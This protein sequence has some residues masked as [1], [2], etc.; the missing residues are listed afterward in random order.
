MADRLALNFSIRFEGTLWNTVALPEKHLVFLELRDEQRRLV[1][2]SG[3]QYDSGNF[4]WKDRTYSERWWLGLLTAAEGVLL[5]QRFQP[6]HPQLKTLVAVDADTGDF[7]WVREEFHLERVSGGRI[8]GSAGSE[9]KREACLD[10]A[11]GN[12]LTD[13][14]SS[15]PED[16]KISGALRPFL[17]H[18]GTPYF[19]TV[20]NYLSTNFDHKPEGGVEYLEFDGKVVISYH[21]RNQNG[22]AN[23]LLVIRESGAVLLNEKMADGLQGLGTDTFFILSGR[24]F[25]VMNGELLLSY[26]LI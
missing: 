23:Y 3:L 18:E 21:I 12:F 9:M 6:D 13:K 5:L 14:S 20:Y 22:L 2:F 1:S 16:R 17:Y 4:L 7:R 11:T 24:L 25:F 10:L 26:Q 15:E 19:I 8:Y